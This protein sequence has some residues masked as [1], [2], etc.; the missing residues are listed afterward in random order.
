M[1]KANPLW[2]L[3]RTGLEKHVN[4]FRIFWSSKPEALP[5]SLLHPLPESHCETH[6]VFPLSSFTVGWEHSLP[7]R[8]YQC[9]LGWDLKNTMVK[10]M[11]LTRPPVVLFSSQIFFYKSFQS[12]ECIA[13][14]PTCSSLLHW[15][16]DLDLW[17]IWNFSGAQ[18]LCAQSQHLGQP[19]GFLEGLTSVLT[20]P[21]G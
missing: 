19:R 11:Y 9:F 5:F 3:G 17:F 7:L 20:L 4:S 21:S 13:L 8:R 1:R 6:K 12:H 18:R 16:Q 10:V 14:T 15:S 2:F